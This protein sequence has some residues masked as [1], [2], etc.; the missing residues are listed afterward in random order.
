V[1]LRLAICLGSAAAG[2]ALLP[3]PAFAQALPPH[4]I[5]AS[6]WSMG[7]RPIGTP[8][9]QGKRYVM[10]A[11]DRRGGEVK[12]AADAYTGR[13]LFVEPTGNRGGPAVADRAYPP[14]YP[15][16]T[17]P[18]QRSYDPQDGDYQRPPPPDSGE[19]SVIYA[20]R[21][22]T[23]TATANP[24]A[25]YRPPSIAKPPSKVAAKPV[26]KPAAAA[27]AESPATAERPDDTGTTDGATAAS[28]PG[29]PAEKNPALVAPPV[30]AFD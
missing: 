16:E 14:L 7:L 10:R 1:K 22:G 5:A 8:V 29:P 24:P 12:V 18:P 11:V 27:T 30:Q 19:P 4:E 23:G 2:L 25:P 17:V 15:E 3:L 9:R 20:P 28:P 26:A 13:V 21:T 6:V